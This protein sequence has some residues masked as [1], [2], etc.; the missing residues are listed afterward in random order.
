MKLSVMAGPQNGQF[1]ELLIIYE[2]QFAVVSLL[3]A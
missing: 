3:S 2:R 1:A